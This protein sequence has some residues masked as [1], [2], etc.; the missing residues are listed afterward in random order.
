MELQGG[1]AELLSPETDNADGILAGDRPG[2]VDPSALR[3]GWEKLPQRQERKGT[4]KR[5]EG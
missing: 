2:G 4:S 5:R 3:P 1:M